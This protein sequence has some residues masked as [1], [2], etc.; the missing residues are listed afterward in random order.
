MIDSFL[1][2]ICMP[3]S[4]GFYFLLYQLH[5]YRHLSTG[6]FR[7][8]FVTPGLKILPI[9]LGI[10]VPGRQISIKFEL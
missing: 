8:N 5:T 3:P 10:T 7:V 9:L 4:D 2:A 1:A 6:G